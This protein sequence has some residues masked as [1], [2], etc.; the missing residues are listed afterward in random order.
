MGVSGGI[1]LCN[2]EQPLKVSTC[3]IVLLSPT[4]HCCL[5]KHMSIP[6]LGCYSPGREGTAS[7]SLASGIQMSPIHL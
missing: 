7:H 2:L 3:R 4:V 6:S 5:D 1:A